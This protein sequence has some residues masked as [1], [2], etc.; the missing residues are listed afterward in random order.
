VQQHKNG[1]V[2]LDFVG[3][4]IAAPVA[5]SARRLLARMT[6]RL[7]DLSRR[8]IAQFTVE[9][10]TYALLPREELEGEIFEV[11]RHNIRLFLRVLDDGRSPTR[12]ELA[13]I[14]ASA[15]R[16]AEERVPLADVLAA[17]HIGARLSW[18][19]M[20]DT[21]GP[22]DVA[23]LFGAVGHILRYMQDL[24]S[25]VSGAYLDVQR[26]IHGE[27]RVA[28]QEL[29][30]ALF[31]GRSPE[32]LAD[33]AATTLAPAHVV[34]VV[35]LPPDPTPA[36]D[37]AGPS[38][39]NA[40]AGPS[41]AGRSAAGA[42]AAGAGAGPSAADGAGGAGAAIAARRRVRLLQEEFDAFAGVPVLGL[43]DARGGTVLLPATATG[44][45]LATVDAA[46]PTLV[47]R[48]TA[49]S[50]G[51]LLHAAA[52]PAPTVAEIPAAAQLA[53]DLVDLAQRL[54]RPSGLYRLDDL[55][56]EYQLTRPGPARDALA[57]KLDPV[58]GQ[59]LLV[60]TL[61]TYLANE[62]QRLRTADVLHVHPNTLG[63]R[64]GRIA[65]LTGLDPTKHADS[66]ILHA[67]L[68]VS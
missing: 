13:G 68:T 31:G 45:G 58:R 32:G 30:S 36:A 12:D 40:V 56:V 41:A 10:P 51:H 37:G 9:V 34:F 22:G 17:Y 46:L 65:A 11:V 15:A 23:E 54:G 49:L 27:E 29:A 38:P 57:H 64:L 20:I 55:L 14:V 52:A 28:R 47:S 4:G 3:E 25:A 6:P 59:P 33:R 18:E 61:R 16:R 42:G 24:T 1:R 19:E 62:R 8:A 60:D 21:S 26:A 67:A 50:D 35:A 63:Y 66:Q 5:P 7:D 43:L 48:L 53:S 39:R 2:T 44:S